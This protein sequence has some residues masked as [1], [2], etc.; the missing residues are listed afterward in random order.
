[1]CR[2]G[3]SHLLDLG[4]TV[5]APLRAFNPALRHQIRKDCF[6][7]RP[8]LLLDTEHNCQLLDLHRHIHI[9]AHKIVDHL[10]ALLI[11]IRHNFSPL[12]RIFPYYDYALAKLL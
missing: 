5:L 11:F 3:S 10:L 4:F 1:M 7:F 8:L 9:V 2:K 12:L 6:Q